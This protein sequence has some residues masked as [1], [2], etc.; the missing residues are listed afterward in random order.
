VDSERLVGGNC[1]CPVAQG[2]EEQFKRVSAAY[3]KLRRVA[4]RGGGPDSDDGGD[5]DGESSDINPFD[6]FEQV[7][8]GKHVAPANQP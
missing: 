4:A 2:A 1:S 6:L 8:N 5:G 3:E 7:R